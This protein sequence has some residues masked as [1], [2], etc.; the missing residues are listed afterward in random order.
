MVTVKSWWVTYTKPENAWAWWLVAAKAAASG[1]GSSSWGSSSWSSSSWSWIQLSATQQS[2]ALA[3]LWNASASQLQ[4]YTQKMASAWYNTSFLSGLNKPTANV[5]KSS[6]WFS[7]GDP[8]YQDT[9]NNPAYV[10]KP[11]NFGALW[12]AKN[13]TKYDWQ[14]VQISNGWVMKNANDF[15]WIDKNNNFDLFWKNAQDAEKLNPWFIQKR[16]DVYAM[17]IK[18]LTPGL[19]QDNVDQTI[20]DY[21]KAKDPNWT[22]W[23]WANWNLDVQN[24]VQAIKNQLW[25]IPTAQELQVKWLTE[26]ATNAYNREDANITSQYTAEKNA[27]LK[28]WAVEDR[29]TNFNEVNDKINNVLQVAGQHRADNLYTWMPNDQQ[30]TEIAQKSWQ[31]FN[32][33]KKILEGR[34]FEDLQLQ[35]EFQKKASDWYD[36]Q[37]QDQE[38]T[39]SRAITDAET[40]HQRTQ[41]A[42]NE[43][44][45]DVK[46]QMESQTN[47]WE[48]AWALS[49]AGRNDWYIQ[50]LNSIRDAAMKNIS[51]LQLRQDRDTTDTATNKARITENYWINT[52]RIKTDLDNSLNQ[53]RTSNGS[54][55][56]TYMNTYMPSS[57]ELTRKL[58][59][60]D[61]KFGNE[62]QLAF[63]N[64]LKNLQWITDTMTY[65][66]EKSLKLDQLKQNLQQT[67]VKNLMENNWAALAWINF[68]DL[69]TMLSSWD[70]SPTDYTSMVWYMKT[71]W[72]SSLQSLG[73]PTSED[74][75]L[76]NSLLAQDVSPQ[77]ALA[78]VV[79]KSPSRFQG[80]KAWSDWK[81]DSTSWNYY[82]T[83]ANGQIEFSTQPNLDTNTSVP[84]TYTAANDS[85]K[86]E[87]DVFLSWYKEWDKAPRDGYCWQFVNDYLKDMW[88][89]NQNLFIDPILE[90]SKYVNSQTPTKWSVMIMDSK[91]KPENGHV[92]IVES[93]NSDWTVNLKEANRNWDKSVHTRKNVDVNNMWVKVYGYFDPSIA[94][95][96]QTTNSIAG[97]Y[98]KLD[99]TQ[100]LQADVIGKN[101]T[102]WNKAVSTETKDNIASLMLAWKD[103]WEISST[104]MD[105]DA[106]KKMVSTMNWTAQV[107]LK[108]AISFAEETLPLVDQTAI[109]A[110]QVMSKSW[111][112]AIGKVQK[113]AAMSWVFG[114]EV[115]QAFTKLNTQLTEMASELAVVYKWGNS[116]TDMWLEQATEMLNANRDYDTLKAN[117][118]L[119]KKNVAL[120]KQSV[121]AVIVAKPWESS[122]VETPA[123]GWTWNVQKVKGGRWL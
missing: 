49:W 110:E 9:P 3:G 95:T 11:V 89:T 43:Q 64:Y 62:S 48:K 10:A 122:F 81:L 32:T 52:A 26:R 80:S 91:S 71:L 102:K 45:D 63:N 67:S 68:S 42:L 23:T 36:R 14:W 15:P 70:I 117:L 30:I 29:F 74:I 51:R 116:P 8:Y 5:T 59:E 69:K 93:V 120:R 113:N 90:K 53:I 121:D 18:K 85:Q 33:T 96:Q 28:Q 101:V 75:S 99:A 41:T 92:A 109:E 16:N 108:Q 111:I 103:A 13:A 118:E 25:I 2:S 87:W 84:N 123:S 17:D 98:K 105:Y 44:I 97:S 76:Y 24:T 73:T 88:I 119:I 114:N 79:A 65:D 31:D 82:R 55:L 72:L 20:I 56:S 106:T 78:S 21:L 94:P 77:Q 22:L 6:T 57:S 34:G 46:T 66:T 47:I 100:K 107:R 35:D 58:D 39:R 37:L 12:N 27:F 19:H 115:K 61:A 38:T 4:T 104:L 83:W 60:L 50:W 1:S 112:T 54:A 86:A 40:Q 7:W